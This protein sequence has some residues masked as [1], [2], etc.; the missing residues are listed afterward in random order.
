MIFD[1]VY[2]FNYFGLNVERTCPF[3]PNVIKPLEEM[4]ERVLTILQGSVSD[5]AESQ[6]RR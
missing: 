1:G 3:I 5:P 6:A 2:M 4:E